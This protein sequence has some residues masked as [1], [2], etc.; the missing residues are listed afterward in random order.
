MKNKNVIITTIILILSM[1]VYADETICNELNVETFAEMTREEIIG[2]LDLQLRGFRVS[3]TNLIVNYDINTVQK[4][5]SQYCIVR[6][7]IRASMSFELIS[8]CLSNYDAFTCMNALILGE[9][10]YDV[11]VNNETITIEPI[12]YQLISEVN[13]EIERIQEIQAQI[14]N[15]NLINELILGNDYTLPIIN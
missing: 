1:M 3:S 13:M 10:P 7:D 6:K 9:E 8:Y 4:Q 2:N 12:N 15:E 11:V 5:E 14:N